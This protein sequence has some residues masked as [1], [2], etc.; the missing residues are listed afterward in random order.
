MKIQVTTFSFSGPGDLKPNVLNKKRESVISTA[1]TMRVL[2][3]LRHWVSKHTQVSSEE[4]ITIQ[5]ENIECT[6]GNW[7]WIPCLHRPWFQK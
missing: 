3:V 2:N 4:L 7:A 1:A 6:S 5:T